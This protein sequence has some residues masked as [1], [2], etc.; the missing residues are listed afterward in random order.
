MKIRNKII[1]M[2]LLALIVVPSLSFAQPQFFGQ[3][4]SNGD[5]IGISQSGFLGVYSPIANGQTINNNVIDL[6]FYNVQ[7]SQNISVLIQ[8]SQ[9]IGNHTQIV[10]NQTVSFYA[11]Q[12]E[13]LNKNISL[14]LFKGTFTVNIEYMN[15]NFTF[16]YSPVASLFPVNIQTYGELALYSIILLGVSLFIF[17]LGTLTAEGMIKRMLYFPKMSLSAIV[18]SLVLGFIAFFIIYN[19]IYLKILSIPYYYFVLPV[20]F[21]SIA[22]E[23]QLRAPKTKE[24]IFIGMTDSGK[25][26]RIFINKDKNKDSKNSEY[27][28]GKIPVIDDKI[29]IG[30]KKN[31]TVVIDSSSFGKAFKRLF[32]FY[33]YLDIPAGMIEYPNV[34]GDRIYY[35]SAKVNNS[36][37]PMLE[38]QKSEYHLFRNR[39]LNKAK[40]YKINVSSNAHIGD[41]ISVLTDIKQI[42]ALAKENNE[43]SKENKEL[44]AKI[45]NGSLYADYKFIRDAAKLIKGLD[46]LIPE[47]EEKIEDIDKKEESSDKTTNNQ[48]GLY[49]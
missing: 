23:L 47:F 7:N 13:I 2:S 32:G 38:L 25:I 6:T 17:V 20:Y 29:Q 40:T 33:T 36:K 14:Y 43:Y 18:L 16:G 22:I 30:N 12:Y 8:Y 49:Q 35:F 44:H 21:M 34:K 28:I 1:I 24:A 27:Y 9:T 19:S 5:I 15:V 26:E 37:N 4:A 11:L 39:H 42:D 10:R 3:S 45:K 46:K 31:K 48:E 41:V